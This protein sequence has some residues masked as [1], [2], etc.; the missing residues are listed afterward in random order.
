MNKKLMLIGTGVFIAATL[1]VGVLWGWVGALAF[2][3]ALSLFSLIVLARSAS[4]KAYLKTG[5][6][7]SMLSSNPL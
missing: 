4:L 3:I 5:S 6:R 2:V 1:L 7:Q